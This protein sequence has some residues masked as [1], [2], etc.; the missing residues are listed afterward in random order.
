MN[1]KKVIVFAALASV[2]LAGCSKDES[3][4]VLSDRMDLGISVA[5]LSVS[6]SARSFTTAF[7]TGT[8]PGKGVGIFINGN[9]YTP[10]VARY[11][12]DG[13][14]WNSSGDGGSKIYLSNETATVYGFYPSDSQSDGTLKNDGTSK[15]K[16]NVPAGENSFNATGQIDYM[17][18]TAA[19][20]DGGVT[21]PLATATNKSTSDKHK[22]DLCF[23]HAL[24]KLSFVVNRS[25]SYTG[26]GTLTQVKLTSTGAAFNVGNGTMNVADGVIYLTGTSADLSFTGSKVI[27]AFANPAS[28]IPTV[29]EMMAPKASTAGITI[30]FTIDGKPMSVAMPTATVS[31]WKPGKNYVYT[32]SVRSTDIIVT[33]VSIEDWTST[34]SGDIDVS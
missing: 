18:A 28:A 11:T 10:L 8:E 25:S 14:N 34:P 27:N 15:I 26:I 23:H 16:V 9:L 33:S 3:S 6:P 20:I 31:E 2:L 1:M 19:S 13:S 22:V 4:G 30:Y 17:Y 24:S 5:S 32:V 7:A 29:E 12:F 21:F